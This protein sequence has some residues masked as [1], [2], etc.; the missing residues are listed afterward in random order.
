MFSKKDLQSLAEYQSQN[1]MVL[2]LYLNVDP[3]EQTTDEYK[4]ALRQMLKEVDGVAATADLEAVERYI[5]LEYDWS[6]RGVALFSCAAD[7]FW[8]AY[9]LAVPVESQ[10]IV[11]RKPH[12]T[13]LADLWD[14]YG[15][16]A[17]LQVDREGARAFFFTMGELV[18]TRGIMGESIKR[19]KQG[20]WGAEKLQ[21]HEDEVAKSNLKE[22]VNFFTDFCEAFQP[23]WLVVA[24]TEPTLSQV[25][26]LMPKALRD[27]VVG[28][29]A[30]E[31][32]ANE[33]EI[34]DRSLE[35]LREAERKREVALVEA[36]FTAA[37]KGSNGVWRLDDTLGAAFEGRIQT[38]LVSRGFHAP[39]YR[40]RGCGYVTA[41]RLEE[42][43]FCGG[44][45]AEIP[46]AVEVLISQVIEQGGRV[47]VI[48]N[49]ERLKEAGVGALL[50]Y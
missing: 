17:V 13:P 2:S 42:C 45:V 23:R 48:P 29:F 31:M 37:A 3:R 1:G 6:G 8:R 47:E 5:N 39:G 20:G 16:Y 4:L 14:A 12:V 26:D 44:E 24:G 33:N 40:C 25:M 22:A 15:R 9:K 46:D 11:A 28:T 32:T 35:V 10:V 41:H 19:H 50:R 49:N 43:P 21:R 18:E 27:K 36:A 34:R 7:D 38:L 30:A